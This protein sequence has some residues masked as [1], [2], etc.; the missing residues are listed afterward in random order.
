MRKFKFP[1]VDVA[2]MWMV[3]LGL[4][5]NMI[6]G[7]VWSLPDF[8]WGLAKLLAVSL[9]IIGGYRILDAIATRV[10][11]ERLAPEKAAY[12]AQHGEGERAEATNASE[13]EQE[14][15]HAPTL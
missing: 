15:P 10:A 11:D 13:P 1:Q 9:V 2:G 8:A 4:W 7:C 6:A 12:R 14:E 3:G 5:C